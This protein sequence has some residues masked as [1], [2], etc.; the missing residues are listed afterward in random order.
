[1]LKRGDSGQVAVEQALVMP[2]MV[3]LVLGI[4]QLTMMQQARIMTEYAAYVAART[5]VVWNGDPDKMETAATL[6]L[7]PTLGRS[8]DFTNYVKTGVKFGLAEEGGKLAGKLGNSIISG[9]N[10][11]GGTAKGV[12]N[13]TR[14]LTM[15][16][17][18]IV[19]PKPDDFK[20]D[21]AKHL[22][23][24]QIDFD[25]IRKDAIQANLLSIH[26]RFFYPLRIPL[27]NWMI[28]EMWFEAVGGSQKLYK[29]LPLGIHVPGMRSSPGFIA[30]GVSST[31]VEAM[32]LAKDHSDDMIVIAA[33]KAIK[34]IYLFPI[35]AYYTMR[36]QSNLYLKNVKAAAE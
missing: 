35:N 9:L 19:N 33:A 11:S 30:T 16:A 17:V 27:A 1:M 10:L 21:I 25:D 3:F 2:L 8:D 36:M 15:V 18:T 6:A 20:K 34:N 31:A 28:Q 13:L 24:K 12:N 29:S 5:G 32:A 26:V 23:G 14:A 22:N 4:V 7:I